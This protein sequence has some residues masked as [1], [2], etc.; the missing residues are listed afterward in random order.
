[1]LGEAVAVSV[2]LL[3]WGTRVCLGAKY[4]V[5]SRMGGE[6]GRAWKPGTPDRVA[7]IM[8]WLEFLGWVALLGCLAWWFFHPAPVGGAMA[9][10]VNPLPLQH[11]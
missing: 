4:S 5:K 2:C 8:P 10:D 1:M 7:R 11:L 3:F 9:L 6:R